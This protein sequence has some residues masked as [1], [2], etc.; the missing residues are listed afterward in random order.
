MGVLGGHRTGSILGKA[1]EEEHYM[2]KR[3]ATFDCGMLD[4]K[5]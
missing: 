5:S 1:V 3:R 4:V 2:I